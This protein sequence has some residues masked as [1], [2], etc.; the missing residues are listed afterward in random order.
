MIGELVGE[1]FRNLWRRRLRT[2]LTVLGI[3]AGS[4]AFTV[5]GALAEK[6]HALVDGAVRYYEARIVIEPRAGVPGL[7]FGPLLST[8][9]V[10]AIRTIPGVSAAFAVTYM[11]LPTTDANLAA[12]PIGLPPLLVG[13]DPERFSYAQD[14]DPLV[15]ASGR[16]F[17]RDA[18]GQAAVGSDL[19]RAGRLRVGMPLR[20]QGREFEI[21]GILEPTLTVRD[22]MVFVPLADGQEMLG[23]LLSP[24]LH[25][26]PERI[27][28]QIEVFP[29]DPSR[30]EEL[31]A[32]IDD[33]IDSVRAVSP[34][35]TVRRLRENLMIFTTIALSSALVAL[36]VGA[37]CVFNTMAMAVAE[38]RAEIGVKKA[39]GASNSDIAQEFVAEAAV[40]GMLG[41]ILGLT[42][43][44]TMIQLLAS[45]LIGQGMRVFLV[46][47]RLIVAT[48]C[49]STLLAAAA[50]LY[51]A[52]FAARGTPADAFRAA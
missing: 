25:Q 20:L 2:V 34:R 51:P 39:I 23:A 13:V 31:V 49:L 37:I 12:L 45:G 24:F 1:T 15:L 46:T 10:D 43:G 26:E 22:N 5:M 6:L 16:L 3:T 9:V 36:T 48:L 40:M 18:R 42:L 35:K 4:L 28:S 33:R 8:G 11:L 19:A 32:A 30:T 14:R 52:L 21:V 7:L 44:E 47:P 38:R 41:G 17:V 29:R 27:V 50:G